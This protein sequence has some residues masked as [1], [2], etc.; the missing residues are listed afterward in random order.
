MKKTTT[1]LQ[2]KK[3]TIR[4]L[5]GRELSEVAGAGPTVGCTIEAQTCTTSAGGSIDNCPPTHRIHGCPHP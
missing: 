3:H 5:Q 4:T 2:F 1:K